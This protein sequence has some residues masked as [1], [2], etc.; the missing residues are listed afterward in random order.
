MP[1]SR[2]AGARW[3]GEPHR[4]SSPVVVQSG[5]G[6]LVGVSVVPQKP[7]WPLVAQP[8]MRAGARLPLV[9]TKV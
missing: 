6:A 4:P 8:A 3:S 9:A 5:G 2:A 1:V 7:S